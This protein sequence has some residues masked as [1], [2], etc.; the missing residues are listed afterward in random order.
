LRL[1][2]F[3]DIEARRCVASASDRCQPPYPS[4]AS[5]TTIQ[6][7][8]KDAYSKRLKYS[9]KTLCE[10]FGV[11][12]ENC[13][14]LLTIRPPQEKPEPTYCRRT[15]AAHRRA[16]ISSFFAQNPNAS[17][18]EICAAAS[19]EG[20]GCAPNT[21]RSDLIKLN[22]CASREPQAEPTLF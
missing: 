17:L 21:V 12:S 7:I 11:T 19:E 9:N 5:D 4:S 18:R 20:H 1:A 16:F 2:G 22:G 14:P 8:V 13:E 15:A 3:S 10:L 6:A